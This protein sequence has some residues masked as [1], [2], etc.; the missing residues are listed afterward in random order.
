MN[1]GALPFV[2]MFAAVA[3][4]L[5]SLSPTVAWRSLAAL[6]VSAMIFAAIPVAEESSDFLFVG[7]WLS[8]IATAATV[9]L[10]RA[11]PQPVAIG[12]AINDGAWSGALAAALDMRGAM[13]FALP[14]SLLFMAGRWFN[15]RGY[16]IALK[17]LSSWLIAVGALAMFVSLVP[18]PGYESDHME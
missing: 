3:L 14:L 9:F 11:I 6:S 10:G 2:L 7:F 17:V 18:T 8:M 1:G 13:A 16:G 12:A 15:R 4:A 5:T